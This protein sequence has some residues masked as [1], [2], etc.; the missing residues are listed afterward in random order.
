MFEIVSRSPGGA[1]VQGQGCKPLGPMQGRR[2]PFARA[3]KGRQGTREWE[4]CRPF[5]A[6]KSQT[7]EVEPIQ[8]FAPLAIPSPLRGYE[9][10]LLTRFQDASP[11][12]LP[13]LSPSVST[14]TSIRSSIER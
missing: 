13:V 11:E 3:P 10:P 9:T 8:G 12:S 14:G 6:C 5:G 4:L 7:S 1:A 2:S